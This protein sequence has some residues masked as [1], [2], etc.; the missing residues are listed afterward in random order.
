[1][2]NILCRI[3]GMIGT[4]KADAVWLE[5]SFIPGV[6][7]LVG[8][9]K[10]PRVLDVDDAIWLMTPLGAKSARLLTRS[11]DAVIAGNSFLADWYS[12]YCK[13]VHIVP[14]AIDCRRFFPKKNSSENG[15][16]LFVIGWTGT[17]SNFKYFKLIEKPLA[18][19]LENHRQ[20]RL[21]VVAD[22]KPAFDSIPQSQLIFEAW[23]EQAESEILHKID[24]GIM[25]LAD[26]DWGRGKCGFKMLQYMATGIPVVVSNVGMNKEILEKG[27]CGFGADNDDEWYQC[28]ELLFSRPQLRVDLGKSGRVIV[29]D[30]YSMDVVSGKLAEVFH[31]VA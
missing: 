5:R 22:R 26:D 6:E 11:V 2:L 7:A 27:S 24:V 25:P 29:E 19:F 16:G 15:N 1:M 31:D 10:A 3:P 14:T 18:R 23:T 12:N 21:L 4:Y 28:I 13:K 20:A 9:T 8:L 17:S 30:N